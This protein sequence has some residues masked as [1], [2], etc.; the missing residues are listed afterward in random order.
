MKNNTITYPCRI[1]TNGT[2]YSIEYQR[3]W[4]EFGGVD[5]PYF[6]RNKKI[7]KTDWK[8]IYGGD[9]PFS[10]LYY[11]PSKKWPG[12]YDLIKRKRLVFDTKDTADEWLQNWNKR[13][14]I[15][16]EEIWTEVK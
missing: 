13:F 1:V 3:S 2:Q 11:T 5:W 10:D 7:I 9:D 15:P 4:T 14:E 16:K 8:L 6:W 12:L